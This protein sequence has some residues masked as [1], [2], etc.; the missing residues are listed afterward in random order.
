MSGKYAPED[1]L[2]LSFTNAS[3][4]EMCER[5]HKETGYP[6]EASTFHKLGLNIIKKVEGLV[7][8]ISQINLRSF[9]REQ[10]AVHIKDSRYLMMLS[11]YLLYNRV[12]AKSEFDFSTKAEYDDYLSMNPPTTLNNE[13]V[14]RYG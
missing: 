3:A 11:N 12:V 7:P 8:K 10:I 14:K 6:I 2:V 4:T 9:V 13:A 5:I 1:I